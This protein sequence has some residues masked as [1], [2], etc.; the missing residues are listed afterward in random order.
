NV[1]GN[2]L[3]VAIEAGST[4]GWER[5]VG[6]KGLICGLETFG[7]SAPAGDLFSFFGFTAEIIFSKI[8]QRRFRV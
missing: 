1:P 5:Y 4:L 2:G 8:Q 3:G 6:R 7:A